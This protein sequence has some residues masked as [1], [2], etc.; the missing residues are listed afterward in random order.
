[1]LRLMPC[2]GGIRVHAFGNWLGMFKA[3]SITALIAVL[4]NLLVPQA[5]VAYQACCRDE[6]GKLSF[7][8]CGQ[9]RAEVHGGDDCCRPEVIVLKDRPALEAIAPD[10]QKADAA[11]ATVPNVT[12]APIVF[13]SLALPAYELPAD[14]LQ[15]VPII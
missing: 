11:A 13:A 6:Q 1:M 2:E 7:D 8:H 5:I 10:L 15:S 9:S 4:T 14:A 12:V 3:P